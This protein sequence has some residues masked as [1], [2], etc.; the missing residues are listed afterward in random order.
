MRCVCGLTA[1]G[2]I[3]LGM[4]LA[5]V[6]PSAAL[7]DTPYSV[8]H[9]FGYP[10]GSYPASLLVRG[11][12]GALYGTTREGGAGGGGGAVFKVAADASSFT[13]LHSFDVNQGSPYAGLLLA[14]DGAFY[15]VTQAGAADSGT[16]FKVSADGSSFVVIH[17]F[18]DP[19]GRD[20]LTS[21]LQGSDG[22]L[23]GTTSLGGAFGNGTIFRVE[24]DGSLFEVLHTFDTDGTMPY[25]SLV[26][27]PDGAL[28]GTTAYGGGSSV[29][30][31]FK[32][33]RDGSSFS[34]L[35]SF[36]NSD[37]ASPF[38]GL[39]FGADL[40]LYGTTSGGG[41]FNGGTIFRMAADGSAFSVLHSF[42]GNGGSGPLSG[43]VQGPGG[44]LYGTTEYGGTSGNG[45]VFKVAADGS[46]FVTLHSFDATD[47]MNPYAGLVDGSDGNFYGT[48]QNGGSSNAGTVFRISAD[49]SSFVVLKEFLSP[50]GAGP[51]GRL[52]EGPDGNFYGNTYTGGVSGGWGTVFKMSADGTSFSVLRSFGYSDGANPYNA[53]LVQ[54][55]DGAFYGTTSEG[56]GGRR[57][58]VYRISADGSSFDVLHSFFPTRTDGSSPV[59]G[60][61]QASDGALYG[62]TEYGGTFD[63]G[64]IYKLSPDGSSFSVIYSFDGTTIGGAASSPLVQG[65]DGALYGTGYGSNACGGPLVFRVSLDG[66]SF[67]VL[68]DFGC[69]TNPRPAGDGLAEGANGVLY[70]ATSS[71]G[72]FG[73][74]A[75]FAAAADG[76]SA[77]VLH[78]F[79]NRD[80][81]QPSGLS[82]GPAGLLYGSATFG[83][84]S[85]NGTLFKVATNGSSLS[86]VHSFH[87]ADG[88]APLNAPLPASGGA[89][90]G[91]CPSGGLYGAG[92]L[93]RLGSNR[94]F[95]FSAADYRVPEAARRALITV[96]RKGSTAE[97]ATVSFTTGD[98][99]AQA[100]VN[101]VAT[102]GTLTFGPGVATRSFAVSTKDDFVMGDKSLLLSLKAPSAGTVL[103]SQRTAVLRI[104][105]S[106]SGGRMQF[107]RST[108]SVSASTAPR[109]A[110]LTVRRLGGLASDVT[111]HYATSDGTATAGADYTSA[112]GDLTFSS[113]GTGVTTQA[114]TVPVAQ[115]LTGAKNFTVALSEP[116]GGG[117]LGPMSIATVTILGAQPTLAFSRAIYDVKTSLPSA[118]IT[119]RRSAPLTGVIAVSYGTSALT[120]VPGTDYQDVSGTLI[121]GP[122]ASTRTFS[123]PI[124]KDP[125]V[126]VTRAVQL[127]LS[128]PS[129]NAII[130]AALGTSRLNITD[131]NL[132]PTL[133]FSAATYAVGEATPKA[134]ITVKRTGDLAGTVSVDCGVTGGTAVFGT[135]YTFP[136]SP[137][138]LTF[139]PGKAIQ[140]FLIG[141]V[142]DL[143]DEGTE[144]V[145]LALTNPAWEHGT[146]TVGAQSTAVLNIADNEPT[147]QFASAARSFGEGSKTASV[148]VKRAGSLAGVATVEYTVT[149]GTAIGGG[150]D[151]ALTPGTL[152]FLGN[153][154]SKAIPITLVNDLRA[155][156]PLTID[157]TL[158]SPLLNGGAGLS[159]GTPSTTEVTIREDDVAGE[160]QFSATDF[161]VDELAGV[162]TIAV[163][164]TG[165]AGQ[166]TVEYDTSGGSAVDGT[167]YTGV[168]GTLTFSAT[169]K[170]VTFPIAILD[171]GVSNAGTVRTVQVSLS[172]AGG[173]L[174]LGTPMT[175]TL[176]I[177]KD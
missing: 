160:V 78:S 24:P 113:S 157:L 19:Q 93:Y 58:T 82:R 91:V 90:Y 48:N 38:T 89:F 36:S 104:Y 13:V 31:V 12:D 154:A 151:Y 70:G 97:A 95:E 37:G 65:P 114:I 77:T 1:S 35:H 81:A 94:S 164:R 117:T 80:G 47:G 4:A 175:A 9:T 5:V 86:T 16:V 40:A 133:Q 109:L 162:A 139:G 168:T 69:T 105:N 106:D 146:A 176:W 29:G 51:T 170:T 156:G 169:Q 28:Y 60:V 125:Y 32:M 152:T 140:S 107:A 138:T 15:G 73:Y 74:G 10:D 54:G 132:V 158:S 98:G 45:T 84:P 150:V 147:V 75:V 87:G 64:T 155:D 166:V 14:S 21:L 76:S 116:A 67:S 49:G 46:S 20:P 57:G 44:A 53:T 131:P 92:V 71:G 88:A 108:Y 145:N 112:S 126:D 85:G 61:I 103:G 173:G 43:L 110:T 7:A 174:V 119:V 142:N 128:A 172:N 122:G 100:G 34:V 39:I 143:T 8:L 134:I 177:V 118:V 68:Y 42:D 56:G 72:A 141:I 149:G 102:S 55:V 52:V 130:D 3:T 161:S 17:T 83:G 96:V 101:Y 26:E 50:D 63:S 159:L 136:A 144:T 41:A 59:T 2:L 165:T 27:G 167:D 25:G 11:S 23:Y 127:S 111:V 79:N 115:N 6:A 121:F 120:A 22:A 99:S 171:D 163:T 30:T 66:S 135:D 129:G 148:V 153:Q 124:A 123:I 62:T 18:D 33:A 137:N